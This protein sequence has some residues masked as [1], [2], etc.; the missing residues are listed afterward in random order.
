MISIYRPR[1]TVFD[2]VTRDY[3]KIER[4]KQLKMWGVPRTFIKLDGAPGLRPEDSWRELPE[5]TPAAF[6]TSLV[7]EG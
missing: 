2:L 3:Y 6:K 1:Q 4:I 5:I 7:L